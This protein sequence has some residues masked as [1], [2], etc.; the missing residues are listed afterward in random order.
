MPRSKKR[1]RRVAEQQK[2]IDRARKLIH[3]EEQRAVVRVSLTPTP[4][5]D[6]NLRPDLKETDSQS[7]L[8]LNAEEESN[9]VGGWFGFGGL[10]TGILQVMY[11]HNPSRGDTRKRDARTSKV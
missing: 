3:K 10:Y 11:G 8:S 1:R 5:P 4:T 6:H 7:N 2:N 9:D